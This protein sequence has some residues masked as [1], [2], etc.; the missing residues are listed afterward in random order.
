LLI[1]AHWLQFMQSSGLPHTYEFRYTQN[2]QA[3]AI[4]S[5]P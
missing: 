3:F 4:V 2:L 1:G 5:S